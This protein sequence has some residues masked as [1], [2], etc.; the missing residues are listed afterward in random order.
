[1]IP[2]QLDTCLKRNS[3]P[4]HLSECFRRREL[5]Q[6]LALSALR[7]QGK[8]KLDQANKR[9]GSHPRLGARVVSG[10]A[11]R[12]CRLASHGRPHSRSH[13]V[14]TEAAGIA[15]EK[16]LC[17][18]SYYLGPAASPRSPPERTTP[19]VVDTAGMALHFP[20][21]RPHWRSIR[22]YASPY[23]LHLCTCWGPIPSLG[24]DCIRSSGSSQGAQA[25][26]RQCEAC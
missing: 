24:L 10:E 23:S 22:P 19:S 5:F 12:G 15:E 26:I 16:D 7:R 4:V 13:P 14:Q 1:L 25:E 18:S 9:R 17:D 3:R 11:H 8:A 20:W 6:P 2:K 21:T